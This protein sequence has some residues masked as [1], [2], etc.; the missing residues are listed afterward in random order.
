MSTLPYV[1]MG[2]FYAPK[3]KSTKNVHI[4]SIISKSL[5]VKNSPLLRCIFFTYN[6]DIV[7]FSMKAA[8]WPKLYKTNIPTMQIIHRQGIKIGKYITGMDSQMTENF[9]I[10]KLPIFASYHSNFW[11]LMISIMFNRGLLLTFAR[12]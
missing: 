12:N 8:P 1:F 4:S 7:T 11:C 2:V 5:C 6:L 10:L 3:K 9:M